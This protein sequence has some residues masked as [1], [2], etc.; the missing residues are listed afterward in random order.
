MCTYAKKHVFT[1]YRYPGILSE[2]QLEQTLNIKVTL[3]ED[4]EVAE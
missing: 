2:A 1:V 3:K 4:V